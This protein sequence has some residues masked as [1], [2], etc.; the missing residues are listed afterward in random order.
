MLKLIFLMIAILLIGCS[1]V[2]IENNAI[3][4]LNR[5]NKNF[6]I[7]EKADS[8]TKCNFD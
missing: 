1:T 3:D 5:N 8:S 2:K 4:Y 6:F 7:I